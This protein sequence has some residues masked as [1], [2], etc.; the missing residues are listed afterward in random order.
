MFERLAIGVNTGSP[1]DNKNESP[2]VCE[3]FPSFVHEF[4]SIP[5][6]VVKVRKS[7]APQMDCN[8]SH[9]S[10][11]RRKEEQEEEQA[12]RQGSKIGWREGR[13]GKIV[14]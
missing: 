10:L 4:C 5:V 8:A 12:A 6:P 2:C 14:G 7:M 3:L 13:K 1:T 11:G 9:L